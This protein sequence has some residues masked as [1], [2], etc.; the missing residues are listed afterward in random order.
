M[1][2]ERMVSMSAQQHEDIEHYIVAL[3]HADER[4][5]AQRMMSLALA[6]KFASPRETLPENV[7]ELRQ[8]EHSVRVS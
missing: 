2:D 5:R 4:T 7:V 3:M 1:T 6:W 8:S